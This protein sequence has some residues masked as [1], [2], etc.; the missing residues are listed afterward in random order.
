PI[1]V[2]ALKIFIVSRYEIRTFFPFQLPGETNRKWSENEKADAT[3]V[4]M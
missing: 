1:N 3:V 4:F 2:E